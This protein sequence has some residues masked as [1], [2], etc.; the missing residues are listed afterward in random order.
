MRFGAARRRRPP[1][2]RTHGDYSLVVGLRNSHDKT[3]PAGLACGS[4]VFVC[5]NLAFSGEVRLSRRHTRFIERNLPQLVARAV[6]RLGDLRRQQDQRLDTY[7]THTVSDESAHDL[8]VRAID[9]RVLPVT[10]LPHVVAEWRR[11]S[12]EEFAADG[13]TVWRLFNSFTE[14][15]K[16][17]NLAELPRRTQALHGLLD[18]A[19][20]LAV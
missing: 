1:N 3:F 16:G 2:G 20:G 8:M 7:R 13:P 17:Q 14:A 11:P 12:H 15:L 19:C 10:A 5:D 18:A 6:G 9:A 4:G